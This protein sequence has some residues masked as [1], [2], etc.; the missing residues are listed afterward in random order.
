MKLKVFVTS[1]AHID[2]EW[3]WPL[4]ETIEVCKETFS[5]AL[6]LMEKYPELTYIQSSSLFYEFMEEHYPEIFEEIK[7]R[8]K[9]GNWKIVGGSF[10][11]FD[12]NMPSGESLVRHFLFGQRYFRE[13]FGVVAKTFW[14]P[15]SF[16][17][18]ASLPQLLKKSGL[19]YFATHKLKWNDTTEF[20]Y[21]I[22]KWR[23]K[24]G[25]QVLSLHLPGTYNDYLFSIKKVL[26]NF[27]F[28]LKKQKI[29][30]LMQV[31]GRGDHG[32]GPEEEEL[33]NLRKWREEYGD[34]ID[35]IF[36]GLDEFFEEIKKKYSDK[37]PE[38]VD[39]E[40]YLEFHRGVFT[41]GAP[42][43]WLN[44]YDE[45]AILQAEK[46]YSLLK[47]IYGEEY[48]KKELD[49]AWRKILLNHFHDMMCTTVIPEDYI[50]GIRRGVEAGKKINNLIK[51]G[52]K[53]LANKV[54]AKYLIF[55]PNSW[56]TSA[57]VKIKDNI[58][59]KYQKLSDGSKLVYV[60][61]VPPVGY[62]SL[63]ELKDEP[64]DKVNIR[65]DKDAYVI[66]N[67]Y[68][69]I[70]IS[71][72]KGWIVSIYDKINKRETLRNPIRLRIYFDYPM[73]GRG[74]LIPG[75]IFDAWEV[76]NREMINKYVF[77]DLKAK[78]VKIS[79]KGEWYSSV[80]AEFEYRQLGFWKSKFRLEV[81]LYADKPYAEI[82]FYGEWKTWHRFLKLVIPVN[83]NSYEAVFE[84][85]YGTVKRLDAGRIKDPAIRAKY[86]VSGQRWVDIS[87]GNY[88]VAIIDDSKYGYSWING[89]IELSLLRS[90]TFPL[91]ETH[92]PN[93][94][95]DKDFQRAFLDY[96]MLTLKNTIGKI[97]LHS[98]LIFNLLKAYLKNWS[99]FGPMDWGTHKA[100]IWIYPHKGD[101]SE[102][103]V[104]SIAAELN[105]KYFIVRGGGN[106]ENVFSLVEIE[107]QYDVHI[108]AIKLSEDDPNGI[109]IRLFNSS[110]KDVEVK[111][112][113][114]FDVKEAKE[115]NLIE[116]EIGEV[117]LENGEIKLRFK[118]HEIKT[119]L[120]TF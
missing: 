37:L 111:M 48:P 26:L 41:T 94:Q 88:G 18:P 50:T 84:T 80:V 4:E 77:K 91:R 109:V 16:G 34:K 6:K 119:I 75:A 32:G 19:E 106:N 31:F 44:R 35:F 9:S 52:L 28:Q 98:F 42:I 33:I 116:D 17:F 117:N 68:L 14:L 78:N 108:T 12:P 24:D 15:D 104:P 71:K 114:Y 60:K 107:P 7:R 21:Y 65:E 66:E 69:I 95:M 47:I 115:L 100:T 27:H 74:K 72:K 56:K 70:R 92:A 105:T 118:P 53:T 76:Y 97:I 101:F 61:E 23:S 59:G 39:D 20:P 43:K 120:L 102:G 51:N 36:S 57:Y 99:R 38:I 103:N 2:S 81:G 8:V 54:K 49:D 93:P 87:D 64:N 63:N 45:N 22:F 40:L 13:K 58:K 73:P 30:V 112:K 82:K 10:L 85:P 89:A 29:P 55:N 83:I 113:P 79:E 5:N 1:H 11:E 3:L 110:D 62:K 86:E 25:S 96:K 46:I 67:K 90:P